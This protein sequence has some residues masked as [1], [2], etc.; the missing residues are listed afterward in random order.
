MKKL[1]S[2]L[3]SMLAMLLSLA[4]APN[5]INYQGVARNS[6]GNGISSHL[7]NLRLTI[8]D[9]S[10][11]GSI[12]FSEQRSVTTNT[13]GLFNIAIGS[14]GANNVIGSIAG[15]IWTSGPKFLQVEMDPDGGSSFLNMGTTQLLSVPY[16]LYATTATPV[17]PAGGDLTGTYPNPTVAKIRGVNVTTV[18]PAL[19]SILGY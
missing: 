3:I 8:H 9:G 11:S 17:G 18:A 2:L 4:Q 5:Q 15:I 6:K 16:A 10:G 1:L 13:F 12:L 19:N 14:P 7:I